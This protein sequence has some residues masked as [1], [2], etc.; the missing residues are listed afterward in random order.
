VQAIRPTI[1]AKVDEDTPPGDDDR[2]PNSLIQSD[3]ARVVALAR[4][5]AADEK[6]PWR[7][8]LALED[9]VHRKMTSRDLSQGF[10][11]AADVAESLSGDCTEY[12]VLLAGLARARGIPARV[13]V[14]LVYTSQ[15]FGFHLW[16]EVWIGDRWIPLDATLGRGGIGAAHLKLSQSNLK[17]VS[18]FTGFI[19]VAQVLGRLKIKI[20]AVE[21][22]Q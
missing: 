2:R 19:P 8:A 5:A 15:G 14:G 18:A 12:G 4:E 20:L 17:G 21:G 13:A 22:G 7:I 6:D 11:T 1:P 16:T 9:L 10:A 3:D